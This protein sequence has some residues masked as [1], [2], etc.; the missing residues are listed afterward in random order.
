MLSG[1]TPIDFDQVGNAVGNDAR[2]AAARA[3]QDQQRPLG[4]LHRGALL[5]IEL[6]EQVLHA[7]LWGANVPSRAMIRVKPEVLIVHD[8]M[9]L[10]TNLRV[11]TW[12]AN[13]AITR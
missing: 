13:I 4:L 12:H 9:N 11:V 10:P 2:L 1:G 6:V 8:A 3:G 7:D 5:V